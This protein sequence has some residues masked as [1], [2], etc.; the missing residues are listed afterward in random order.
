MIKN[1]KG[2]TLIELL[3]VIAI[4]GV[5]AGIVISSVAGSRVKADDAKI[6]SNAKSILTQSVIYAD[7]NAGFYSAT[8]TSVYNSSVTTAATCAPA[9]TF[10]ADTVVARAMAEIM[11]ANTGSMRC[12]WQSTNGASAGRMNA[13]AIV[14]PLK[15]TA[16]YWC[17]DYTGV[18]RGM[19]L[20]GTLY[21]AVTGASPAALSSNSDYTCN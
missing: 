5:L 14:V 16:N 13:W 6:V 9:G 18:S 19:N 2:F 3:V 17:I 10:L 11:N 21:N 8:G 1:K 20:S 7:D 15:T 12:N 4:I